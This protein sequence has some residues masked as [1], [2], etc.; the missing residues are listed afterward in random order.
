MSTLTHAH[1]T[2]SHAGEHVD[3]PTTK[4]FWR[5]VYEA[6]AAS[7]QRRAEREIAAFLYGRGSYLTDDTEREMMERLMGGP[8]RPL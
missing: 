5:R 7:Q 2:F 3:Q 8:R 4:S 6:I 1:E